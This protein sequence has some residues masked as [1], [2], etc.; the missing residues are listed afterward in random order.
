MEAGVSL[1]DLNHDLVEGLAFVEDPAYFVDGVPV[2]RDRENRAA[3]PNRLDAPGG[4]LVKI[5]EVHEH[6]PGL[7][8]VDSGLTRPARPVE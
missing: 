8:P 4:C 1:A 5:D 3:Y 7:P 6:I 2:R